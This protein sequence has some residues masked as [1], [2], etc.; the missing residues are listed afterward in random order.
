MIYQSSHKVFAT[1]QPFLVPECLSV[2]RENNVSSPSLL[3]GRTAAMSPPELEGTED[4][5]LVGQE[6]TS[7]GRSRMVFG[8]A[9]FIIAMTL[10]ATLGYVYAHKEHFP[11]RRGD[12]SHTRVTFPNQKDVR[13]LLEL[14]QECQSFSPKL[15]DLELFFF[16]D[17][18]HK[19]SMWIL[20][21]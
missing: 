20:L 4:A 21:H 16:L 6:K 10:S 8:A 14:L 1:R 15:G 13:R 5:P 12:P 11:I 17:R 7:T 9:M 18:R 3:L 2:W 19:V